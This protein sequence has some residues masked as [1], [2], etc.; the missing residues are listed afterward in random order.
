M[1]DPA[2]GLPPPLNVPDAEARGRLFEA[3]VEQSYN[4]VLITDAM[5]SPH[6][7]RV[8]YANPAF[9][10]MTGYTL[11]E[12][13][14]LSPR[15]LQGPET[16][17]EVIAVLRT[18]IREGR[19]FKGATYNYRKDGTPYVVEWSVSPVR[20]AQGEITH[21]VSVQ[22]DISGRVAAE[23]DRAM[24]AQALD[25]ATASILITDVGGR[26]V[27]ANRGFSQLTG[28]AAEEVVGRT[29][30]ILRSGQHS[31]DFYARL[32][33]ELRSGRPFRET[34]VNRRKDGTLFHAE[35]SIAPVRDN[36]GDIT[37]FIS[38]S[39]DMTDRVKIERALRDQALRDPLTGVHNRRAG[40]SVL[41]RAWSEAIADGEPFSVIVADIDHFKSINDT[42]GHAV[43]DRVL[44][45]VAEALRACVRASDVLVRW[46]GEEFLVVAAGCPLGRAADLAERMRTTVAECVD[47][48]AGH[49]TLSLGV[50]EWREGESAEATV[51]RAD[52]ALYRA[53]SG[54]RNRVCAD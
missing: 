39:K 45:N 44:I 12:L 2:G 29:P 16:D 54:G 22:H 33:E 20:D 3:V 28:Y 52:E 1:S 53:K 10:R 19:P 4:S 37:H 50:A 15:M 8:V 27:F 7:P 51:Q 48:D 38:V 24:L 11:D 5:Q 32:W 40:E 36:R 47:E 31:T 26:I 17:R 6:G 13:V 34:F 41:A 21:F 46:G 42:H 30:A 35:Q 23:R 49:V 18:C 9:C 43:G 25:E 14:G